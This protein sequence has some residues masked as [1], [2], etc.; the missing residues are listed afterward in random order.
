M[1]FRTDIDQ[2]KAV[3][4]LP[5]WWFFTAGA[6]HNSAHLAWDY[7]V[8]L[9]KNKDVFSFNWAELRRQVSRNC[10]LKH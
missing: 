10:F 8:G 4:D 2:F 5:L 7:H 9:S 1:S 6:T 3:F